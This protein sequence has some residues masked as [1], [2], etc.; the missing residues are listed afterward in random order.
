[1]VLLTNL[2][3]QVAHWPAPG[4]LALAESLTGSEKNNRFRQGAR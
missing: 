3:D 4:L 1:L 2:A